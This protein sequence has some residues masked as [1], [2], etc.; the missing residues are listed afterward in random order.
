M[1][2]V[3]PT[4]ALHTGGERANTPRRLSAVRASRDDLPGLAELAAEAAV[5]EPIGRWLVPEPG[6]RAGVLR[7]WYRLLLDQAL[8]YGRID[9]LA[10]CSAA[11]AWIDR[12]RPVPDLR[13]A[14][15]RLTATCGKH[16]ITLLDYHQ[17]LH[18]TRPIRP[19]LDLTM[20][21]APGPAS[22]ARLLAHRHRRL[23]LAGIGTH[24]V[25]ESPGLRDLLTAAGYHAD[26]P[27]A[28][29]AEVPVWPMWRQP[30]PTAA[31]AQPT[32]PARA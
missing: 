27:V 11:A 13:L 32:P 4:S 25:A 10:D 23:D 7:A 1:L 3:V 14:L 30:V 26:R 20:L 24:A 15:R 28:A 18:Q 2:T 22:A 31:G 29:T 8:R 19:H 16:A 17:L 21:A 12:T 6:Q 5:D 9:M